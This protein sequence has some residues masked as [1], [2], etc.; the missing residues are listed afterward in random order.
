MAVALERKIDR[1]PR[2]VGI[3]VE[4]ARPR[5]LVVLCEAAPRQ[6]PDLADDHRRW[7]EAVGPAPAQVGRPENR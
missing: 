4:R 2:R 7:L 5:V 6:F 3:A 1:K